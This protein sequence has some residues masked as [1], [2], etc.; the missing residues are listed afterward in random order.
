VISAVDHID[1]K[2]P[3]LRAASEFLQVLGFEVLR[4]SGDSVELALPGEDQVKI[5]VREDPSL[6]ATQ[7]DHIAFRV[8][9][10]LAALADLKARGVVF[11]R[12]R[13]TI[14]RT[15]RVVSNFRD[16]AGGKWQLAE[17]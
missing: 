1:L 12:E 7:V 17:A 10:G 14:A 9:D 11:D 8:D 5:E 15:G 16:P 2:V 4:D 3:D 13:A 6:S